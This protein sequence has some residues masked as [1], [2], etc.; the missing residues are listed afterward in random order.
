MGIFFFKRY[1][2]AGDFSGYY[3]SY[4]R[5]LR[6]HYWLLSPWNIIICH[7]YGVFFSNNRFPL[8]LCDVINRV[9]F[10]KR[11]RRAIQRVKNKFISLEN[12]LTRLLLISKSVRSRPGI[13]LC[14]QFHDFGSCVFHIRLSIL[15]VRPTSV[16]G[17]WR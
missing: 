13:G 9:L 1:F 11:P 8:L 15:V 10:I 6:T 17:W 7:A 4:I 3:V 5:F 14:A 16:R 2:F 12:T